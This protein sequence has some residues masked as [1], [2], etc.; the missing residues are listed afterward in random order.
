MYVGV[1]TIRPSR[2]EVRVLPNLPAGDSSST[3]IIQIV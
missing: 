3:A 2:V 1:F